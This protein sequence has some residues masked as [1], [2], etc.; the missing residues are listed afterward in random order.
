MMSFEQEIAAALGHLREAEAAFR[1]TVLAAID[2]GHPITQVADAAQVTRQTIYRWSEATGDSSRVDVAELL[3]DALTVAVEWGSPFTAEYV[4]GL[5]SKDLAV[6]AR[7]THAAAA[8]IPLDVSPEHSRVLGQAAAVAARV[9]TALDEGHR[10]P[11]TVT[12]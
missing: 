11:R 3:D 10:P 2:A 12:L 5:R 7:R 9:L 8:R 6:K 1:A 4:A